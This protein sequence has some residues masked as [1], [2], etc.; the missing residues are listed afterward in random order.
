MRV[1]RGLDRQSHHGTD[2]AAQSV[3]WRAGGHD[4]VD[5]GLALEASR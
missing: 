2:W 3:Q 1:A 4:V 5:A